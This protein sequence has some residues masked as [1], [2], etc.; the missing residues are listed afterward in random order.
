MKQ[1]SPPQAEES[2]PLGEILLERGILSQEELTRARAESVETV[3]PLSDILREEKKLTEKLLEDIVLEYT[4]HSPSTRTSRQKSRA[5]MLLRNTLRAENALLRTQRAEARKN[6]AEISL[7]RPLLTRAEQVYCDTRQKFQERRKQREERMKK[8]HEEKIARVEAEKKRREEEKLR[9]AE[10]LRHAKEVLRKKQEEEKAKRE[11]ETRLRKEQ[12]KRRKEER[13]QKQAAEKK[14][15]EE[16]KNER[17]RKKQVK[18]EEREQQKA[19]QAMQKL[20]L[21]EAKKIARENHRSAIREHIARFLPSRTREAPT[22]V[23]EQQLIEEAH[24]EAVRQVLIESEKRKIRAGIQPVTISSGA[25]ANEKQEFQES[26]PAVLVNSPERVVISAPQSISQEQ[27]ATISTRSASNLDESE[28]QALL[29]R[30]HTLEEQKTIKEDLSDEKR[31]LQAERAAMAEE[32]KRLESIKNQAWSSAVSEE[33]SAI[34]AAQKELEVERAKLLIEK[35]ELEEERKGKKG[36]STEEK[37]KLLAAAEEALEKKLKEQEAKFR[38]ERATLEQTIAKMKTEV[39]KK[40]TAQSRKDA[41][42]ETAKEKQGLQWEEEKE[43][44]RK[45]AMADAE[46]QFLATMKEGG[47]LFGGKHR[48]ALT[49]EIDK[50]K[51]EAEKLEKERFA[52]EQQK[53]LRAEE[54]R[55]VD[56]KRKVEQEKL[57]LEREKIAAEKRALTTDGDYEKVI[58]EE[59][60]QIVQEQKELEEAKKAKKKEK[61][62]SKKEQEEEEKQKEQKSSLDVG[63]ILVAQNYLEQ[64]EYEH[65]KKEADE[66]KVTL[67]NILREEGLVTKDII[68][69]AVAEYYQMPFVDVGANPPTSDI[70]ELLPEDL[71]LNLRATAIAKKGEDTLVIAT[72][73]P[74]RGD[75]I[76]KQVL[77]NVSGIKQVEMVYT[78][79]DA[80]D[81]ALSFYRKPLDTRFQA[82]IQEHKKIAPEIIEEIFADAIQLGASDIHFEPQELRVVVRF[83]VD[84]V[85]HEAGRLPREYYEGIVNRIKIAGNMRIDEHFAAQDG[86]IRWKH[87]DKAMDV[88]V[89]IVPIVDGEKIVMR[90]LSEYVRTLTLRDLGFSPKHL[91]VLVKAAHKPFGMVLTTGPT[92]SGK[93]TTLY[94]LMKIRNSPDVNISTIEDPVEYKILGINHIQVN[95]KANLTFERGLRALVRQDPDI[96]LVGEIR[97]DITAQ[98]SVNAALTGHLLFSTLHANDAATAVPRL[99]EMGIEPYLL[100][101]TLEL[102]IA[103]RLMRRICTNCRYSYIVSLEEA[104]KSFPGGE[105]YFTEGSEVILYKGKGCATCG[106]TG[107]KGRV[108]VYEL[109]IMTPE[110]EDMITK[111]RTSG[112]INAMARRQGMLTLF[113]DGLEK[114]LAGFST[115]DEL[116]RVAAPPDPLGPAPIL[117]HET[118]LEKEE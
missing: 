63:Q 15:R 82:I 29:E 24:T 93:S 39:A 60:A 33:R 68:Q 38:A 96:I 69:N 98:I 116:L 66:R 97:D 16:E 111:R 56:E 9:I 85:M 118:L 81:A 36:A 20:Y 50:W 73:S 58:D 61:K 108:G 65:A 42:D 8:K 94:G 17:E 79:K 2:K 19:K 45:Q 48:D 40:G 87:G 67:D 4:D 91:D 57:R 25:S 117:T 101:S 14:R 49:K 95:V 92:G 102:I 41:E 47:G 103:Q 114:A 7:V 100:A 52:I 113:E 37:K 105:R 32:K 53:T 5:K 31:A 23:G 99:L 75:E 107:Y 83:R 84:G 72:S 110:I 3:R 54:E 71:A 44:I 13:I 106:N 43:R 51:K 88:R 11:E 18:R 90:L 80:I 89:S 104:Q 34:D 26:A 77:A 1:P 10:E 46:T 62:K 112:E 21:R 59:K 12:D 76:R 55:L 78:S 22:T 115:I 6:L 70:V 28:K 64:A 35:Q 27:P 86:A 74:D 109:L 30:I